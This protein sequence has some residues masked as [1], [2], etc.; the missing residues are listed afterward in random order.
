MFL[1]RLLI[2]AAPL[3][4]QMVAAIATDLLPTD[5]LSSQ[6]QQQQQQQGQRSP[7]F[8]LGGDRI[9]RWDPNHP[10]AAPKPYRLHM[11]GATEARG[12]ELGAT[13]NTV[14]L[15]SYNVMGGRN[16]DG[17][18]NFERI[19]VVINSLSPDIV[20]LQ[21]I[22]ANTSRINGRDLLRELSVSTSLPNT[23][24]GAAIE[25]GG[26]HYGVGVL[27]R[28]KIITNTVH[29]LPTQ[30]PD[31]EDRVMLVT[32]FMKPMPW[33]LCVTHL[34]DSDSASRLKQAAVVV[35]LAGN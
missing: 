27:S 16:T 5:L 4:T 10:D 28:Y 18:L 22:D 19:A 14:R 2:A 21:E 23:A 33:R 25:L 8:A 32:S 34:T 24:F 11:S 15:L 9:Q 35:K 29:K 1:L 26:G 17:S 13:I 20:A 31:S 6:Q 30:P 7:Y 12:N 3:A